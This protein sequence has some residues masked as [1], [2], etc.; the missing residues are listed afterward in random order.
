MNMVV[1][2]KIKIVDKMRCWL[3]RTLKKVDRH[4]LS[5]VIITLCE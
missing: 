1:N 4:D 5:E 3:I 2:S